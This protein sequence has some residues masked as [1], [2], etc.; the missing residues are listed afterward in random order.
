MKEDITRIINTIK[1][2]GIDMI[3]NAKSGNPG[4]TLERHPLCIPYTLTI[5]MLTH[6]I[7]LGTIGIDLLCLQL[8]VPLFYMPLYT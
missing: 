8:M 2:L 5:S 7:P 6:L 3:D 1:L 4:I